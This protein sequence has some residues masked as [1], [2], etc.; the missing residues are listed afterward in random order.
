MAFD[1]VN[2]IGSLL[3]R[4]NLILF[5]G[6]MSADTRTTIRTALE[7]VPQSNWEERVRLAIYLSMISPDYLILR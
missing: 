3:E 4:L 1:G 6:Q 2:E 5:H 7:Q